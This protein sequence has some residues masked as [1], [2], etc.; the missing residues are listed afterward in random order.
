MEIIEYPVHGV[1]SYIARIIEGRSRYTVELYLQESPEEHEDPPLLVKAVNWLF[2]E[3]VGPTAEPILEKDFPYSMPWVD[4]VNRMVWEYER[5]M[6]YKEELFN[7]DGQVFEP[8]STSPR[9]MAKEEPRI[10][11]EEQLIEVKDQGNA[12]RTIK[13]KVPRLVGG[14]K[15]RN[16]SEM[17]WKLMQEEQ[18]RSR[19]ARKVQGVG[20]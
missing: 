12:P 6:R 1:Q 15:P 14:K 8:P 16:M 2:G 17:A 10:E 9:S 13:Q 11:Y 7:W 19:T 3:P 18:K 4:A 5:P 20:G